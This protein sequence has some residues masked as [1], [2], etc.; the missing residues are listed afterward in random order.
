[1]KLG[2]DEMPDGSAFLGRPFSAELVHTWLKGLLPDRQKSDPLRAQWT[3]RQD[4]PCSLD[5]NQFVKKVVS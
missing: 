2:P 1:M 5:L 4:L 3:T